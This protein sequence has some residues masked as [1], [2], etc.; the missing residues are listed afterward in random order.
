MSWTGSRAAIIETNAQL[1]NK[2]AAYISP[3]HMPFA[4]EAKLQ[5]SIEV[6]RERRYETRYDRVRDERFE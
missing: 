5:L 1:L 6:E 2:L 4:N 3:D